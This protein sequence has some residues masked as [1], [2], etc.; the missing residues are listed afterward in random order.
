MFTR[1]KDDG[2]GMLNKLEKVNLKDVIHWITQSWEET[3]PQTLARS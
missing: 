3:E 1:V 2:N